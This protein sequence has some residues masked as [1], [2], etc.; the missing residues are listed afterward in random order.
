MGWVISPPAWL[1]KLAS[2]G[3]RGTSGFTMTPS[4]QAALIRLLLFKEPI[5]SPT[6]TGP[7]DSTART[8]FLVSPLMKTSVKGQ[9][10]PALA[11][12]LLY[13][14]SVQLVEPKR[15]WLVRRVVTFGIVK[16][17]R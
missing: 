6:P 10:P 17:C 1:K 15:S 2:V 5:A 7:P 14:K 11:K 9:M 16:L 12:R 4:T 13:R 8:N 3:A